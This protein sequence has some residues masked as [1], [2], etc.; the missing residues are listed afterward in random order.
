M[1]SWSTILLVAVAVGAVGGGVAYWQTRKPPPPH[2]VTQ[3]VTRGDLTQLVNATGMLNPVVLSPVGSQVSGIV[4]KLHADYNDVVKKDQVLLELDP[5]IFQAQVEQARANLTSALANV[6]KAKA[7]LRNNE[8]IASRDEA[9]L[10][11][12]Y[13]A[14]SDRDTA[15]ANRD[16]SVASVNAAEAQVAQARASLKNAELNL[17]NSVIV[18]PVNGVVIA[19][20]V[21]LG[22]AVAASFQAPNL[23]SIAADLT[24]MQVL[25]NVDEADIGMVQLGQRA[26]FSV[27]SFRNRR[28]VATVSQIR[29]SPQTVQ[30]VVTYVV[31]LDVDNSALLLRP[32]M[33]ANVRINVGHRDNVL[34][35]PNAALRFKPPTDLIKGHEKTGDKKGHRGEHGGGTWADRGNRA[36]RPERGDR[37]DRGDRP[38]QGDHSASATEGGEHRWRGGE[39]KS[40]DGAE[41][42]G[43][44]LFTNPGTVYVQDGA[45]LRPVPVTTGINDGM[46][47]ELLSGLEEGQEVVVDMSRP[48]VTLPQG[49]PP[50]MGGMGGPPGGGGGGGRR[51]F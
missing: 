19:R 31:V 11:D 1:K 26:T 4:W 16:G 42:N 9:L 44:T 43:K 49:G 39:H 33:T 21:E 2:F 6:V 3:K 24:K 38:D 14:V 50:G 18:S 34:L 8:L 23:F 15:V 47:T 7:D 51:G 32:G 48:Q 30:N 27:D 13:V 28:F 17:K 5:A 45:L 37:A 12:H 29:N 40:A 20:S 35:V 46:Q 36:D 41:G 25:A 22:Q 10:K